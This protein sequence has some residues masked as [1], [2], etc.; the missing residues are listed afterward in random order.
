MD[1]NSGSEYQFPI[2]ISSTD[3][4]LR[5]LRAELQRFLSELGYRPILSSA[6]GFADKAPQL[7]PWECC[8]PVLQ[9]CFVVILVI[10]AKYGQR[11][12][13]PSFPDISR[14]MDISP[15]HAEYRLS[16]SQR[17]RM[18]VFVR[19]EISSFYSAYRKALD[20]ANGDA[21]KAKQLL[22]TVLPNRIS[23]DVLEFFEEVKRTSP[24]PWIRT[25]RDVTDIKTEVRKKLL[26]ELAEVF[27]IREGHVDTLIQKLSE[28]LEDLTPEA[29]ERALKRIGATRALIEG[30]ENLT[31]ELRE[32]KEK[33]L[34]AR[35]ALERNRS[36]LEQLEKNSAEA[37]KLR[38][39]VGEQASQLREL[40][41]QISDLERLRNGVLGFSAPSVSV[42]SPSSGQSSVLGSLGKRSAGVAAFSTA[43]CAKCGAPAFSPGA[44][45]IT[46]NVCG[47]CKR[48]LCDKCWNRTASISVSTI[49]PDC[50]AAS[51]GLSLE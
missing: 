49:C 11:F 28:V 25:F 39:Q 48:T 27:L 50:R 15:T 33:E 1:T 43:D 47:K 26:N 4:D 46:P 9:Q 40:K 42:L 6:E 19:E 10:D 23:P 21:T 38:D 12:A 31:K 5:D 17:K 22:E 20:T 37:A 32:S 8:L 2:F 30:F 18:L 44:T 13:W 34:E 14:G 51:M 41:S 45:L 3:Y 36:Q 7:Q 24:I 16:L 35:N 29:R